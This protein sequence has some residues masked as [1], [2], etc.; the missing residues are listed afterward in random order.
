MSYLDRLMMQTGLDLAPTAARVDPVSPI[1]E[2]DVRQIAAPPA[3]MAAELSAA[4]PI[5][6]IERAVVA[7]LLAP[8]PMS[9]HAS[10]HR[11]SEPAIPEILIERRVETFAE[12]APRMVNRTMREAAAEQRPARAPQMTSAS[13]KD[14]PPQTREPA[15]GRRQPTFIEIR[16][17][18][19]S[20]PAADE[21]PG[22]VP[23]E[24]AMVPRE[25]SLITRA[26]P[27]RMRVP[28]TPQVELSIGTMQ[29]IVEAP[30][31][32]AQPVRLQPP[33]SRADAA[34]PSSS[35]LSRRYIRL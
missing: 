27:Q 5:E 18:V 3:A 24:R 14:P 17:W 19:A 16:N 20:T 9:L 11:A 31:T 7:P 2:I 30:P 15:A 25:A 35:R 12:P 1:V 4:A 29:V 28:E 32:Q 26:E 21:A 8:D 6:R 34:P 23:A 10:L 33:A 13:T 22:P